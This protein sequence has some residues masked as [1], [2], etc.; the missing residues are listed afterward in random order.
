[1]K[2]IALLTLL[3]DKP[4]LIASI[5]GVAFAATLAFVQNA[6]YEGFLYTSSAMITRMGGDLWVMAS[7]TDV[8]DNVEVLSAGTRSMIA[9]HPCVTRVR[10]LIFTWAFVRKAGK[11]RDTVRV[12]GVDPSQ[13]PLVP[14]EMKEGL[15]SDLN[16]P[17]RIGIDE[18]DLGKL[19]IKGDP[20][21]ATMNIMG[22]T[23]Y[24]SAVTRGVRSFT[25]LPF[26]FANIP[27]A[28]RLTGLSDGEV[29][30]WVLDV[31][32]KQCIPEV[33]AYIEKHP[34]L[35][36]ER[37]KEFVKKSQDYWINGS[38]IGAVLA[39]SALLGLMVGGVI[40]GQTLYSMARDYQ[41]ELSTLKAIGATN[42]EIVGFVAWQMGFMMTIGT[43]LGLL[44]S[45]VIAHM[46][47]KAG[48]IMILSAEVIFKSSM[49]IALTCLV[50]SVMSIRQIIKVEAAEVFQ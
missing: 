37:T 34:E 2:K 50:A 36:A 21:R 14:W 41:M 39:F 38:G 8:L 31:E 11:T 24:V 16:A 17:M 4:K 22:H 18:C 27:D 20:M 25:L 32:D 40:V 48:M 3:Y 46:A 13:M 47:G 45:S 49:V 44:A 30:Y 26:V 1:M 7:G 5:A 35:Q 12:V 9:N 23:V 42:F 19:Q 6:L 33:A 10:P 29:N 43:G 15:P 28:R